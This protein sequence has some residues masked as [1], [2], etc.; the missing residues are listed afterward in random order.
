MKKS[1]HIEGNDLYLSKKYLQ[2]YGSIKTIECWNEETGIVKIKIDAETFILYKSVPFRTRKK[3]PAPDKIIS[4]EKKQTSHSKVSEL[5]HHAF[6]YKYTSF[7][8]IYEKEN[9]FTTEQITRFSKLHSVFQTIIDLKEKESFRHLTILH[10][11]FNDLFPGKY[12]T[13]QAFSQV[14]LKACVD[15][16]MSVAMDKRVFGN[17]DRSKRITTPQ[18]DYIMQGLVACNGKFTN[19]VMLEKVNAYSKQIG[20]VEYSLSWVKKHR[21]EWLKNPE[22]YKSRY[23]ATEAQKQL[24]YASLKNANY[25]HVQWQSD[26]VEIPFWEDGFHKSVLV[27]VIDN[28][29]KKI[30]GYAI[31]NTEKSDVIKQ[32]IR[33]AVINTGVLP[34][35]IVM[36]K[37]AFTQ[38]QAAFN[39]ENLLKKVGGILTTTSNPRQ[40]VIVE[41]YI[42][43]LNSLFKNY[44]G[45]LGKSIRSKSIE[46]IT[47]NE[48][49]S[50]FAKKFKTKNEVI[51]IVT[52]VVEE[53]NNKEQR[54]KTPNQ[55]FLDNPHPHPIILNQ[56]HHAELL[57]VQI[58]KQIKSGQITIMRGVEKFEYQLPAHLYQQWNNEIVVVTHDSLNDGIYLFNKAN[59]EGIICLQLKQKINNS[60]ALQTPEDIQGL[61]NNK[62]RLKGIQTQA[63]KQLEETKDKAL[64]IDPEAYEGLNALITPKNVLKELEQNANIKMLAEANGVIINELPSADENFDIPAALK[65]KKKESN[66][67]GTTN[68]K[69]EL[70]D[71]LTELDN[72]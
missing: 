59:G 63:R 52:Q 27:F 14:I 53:Y 62:G 34:F 36:D 67:F 40:K 17:N 26:G 39:F 28:C 50:E 7:K 3:L 23:G 1:I 56:F 45:Y 24:P 51:A 69:I 66:P 71:P 65:P 37:H 19:A 64:N 44:E 58:L 33:N 42:Q 30:I 55:A 16:I 48:Q 70:I 35:E 9:A 11:A 21:R 5:L 10:N 12:K 68:N 61:Y 15:G 54:G 13:K 31:G 29:S 25:A 72:D 41:R 18:I 47:S 57:P 49:K 38:T 46:A 60:K 6:Y 22:I 32:A 20:G 43:N 8:C 4:Q 2:G